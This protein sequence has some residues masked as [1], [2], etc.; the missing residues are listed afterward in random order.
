MPD[1]ADPTKQEKRD[2][3]P[4]ASA[5]TPKVAQP[6]YVIPPGPPASGPVGPPDPYRLQIPTIV[7][8]L[9][10]REAVERSIVCGEQV[11]FDVAQ[12][13]IILPISSAAASFPIFEIK[14]RWQARLQIPYHPA[15][16]GVFYS[17]REVVYLPAAG[18]YF[19]QYTAHAVPAEEMLVSVMDASDPEFAKAMLN[20]A[21]TRYDYAEFTLAP[22]TER[23]V[24]GVGA[25]LSQFLNTTLWVANTGAN[26]LTVKMG[27][28]PLNQGFDVTGTGGNANF[29]QRFWNYN[30]WPACV[31]SLY[32][33]LGTTCKLM[34]GFRF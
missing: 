29:S 5:V 16:A 14:A 9:S 13:T 25:N 34:L 26:G 6:R 3:A 19:V 1:S 22:A 2:A 4:R 12:P 8:H 30:E 18:T 28:F 7:A 17:D 27:N 10:P 20:P 32:S 23:Q 21:T 33:N 15:S 24:T 31:L 11:R